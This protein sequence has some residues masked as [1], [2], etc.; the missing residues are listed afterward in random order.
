[1]EHSPSWEWKRHNGRRA[2]GSPLRCAKLQGGPPWGACKVGE[3]SE[4]PEVPST[5]LLQVFPKVFSCI[6][7]P[8][9]QLSDWWWFSH[10]SNTASKGPLQLISYSFMPQICSWLTAAPASGSEK[11]LSPSLTENP[12]MEL[13]LLAN[14]IMK[15][16]MLSLV[17]FTL[18]ASSFRDGP[19]SSS[20]KPPSCK[21]GK[22][23]EA[24]HPL[25]GPRI[26]WDHSFLLM[27]MG[28][29]PGQSLLDGQCN[30]RLSRRE[31]PPV[32]GNVHKH[33]W[34][35]RHSLNLDFSELWG[36]AFTC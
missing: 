30:R 14:S 17:S 10:I 23:R 4:N 5:T 21:M 9:S 2:R 12:R 29:N 11:N 3:I 1:M 7:Y 6:P 22:E 33:S 15:A 8:T 36:S 25:K 13:I 26:N 16:Q 19:Q 34:L 20:P 28:T 18:G 24:Q 32:S 31:G 27:V 35:I